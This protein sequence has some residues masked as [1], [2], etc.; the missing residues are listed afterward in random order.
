MTAAVGEG[1]A[2][3]ILGCGGP[4]ERDS[5]EVVDD[6]WDGEPDDQAEDGPGQEPAEADEPAARPGHP[7]AYAS[8]WKQILLV[9][10]SMGL[11]ILLAGFVVV[12]LWNVWIGAGLGALGAAYTYA[13]YRRYQQWKGTREAAGLPT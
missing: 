9:D 12:L 13:V 8:N 2:N 7:A 6:R 4:T 10:A 3:P 5:M 11:V 1:G